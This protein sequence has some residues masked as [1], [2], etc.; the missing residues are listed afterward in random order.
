MKKLFVA[1]LLL[2]TVFLTGCTN[3]LEEAFI[4]MDSLN[5]Y[6]MDLTIRDMPIFGTVTITQLYDGDLMYQSSILDPSQGNYYEYVDGQ[7]YEYED[8]G[9]GGWVLS[10]E[11]ASI[12]ET[13]RL[14]TDLD[15]TDF[16]KNAEGT[17]E[18]IPERF[19]LDDAQTSYI[20]EIVIDISDDGYI[21][22]LACNI[23]TDGTTMT[24]EIEFSMFNEVTVTLP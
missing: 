21:G 6:Q 4:K 2:L 20:E 8:D 12:D 19:Y 3:Q 23:T 22:S 10:D 14:V 24:L 1:I 13:S 7:L 9:N 5:S 17:W 15:P 16:E 18:Y 11:V